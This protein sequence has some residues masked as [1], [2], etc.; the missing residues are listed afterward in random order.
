MPPE[1]ALFWEKREQPAV[2]REN[3]TTTTKLA[4]SAYENIE[5]EKLLQ[6]LPVAAEL[7]YQRKPK[8]EEALTDQTT[9]EE[10]QKTTRAK[11]LKI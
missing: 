11:E 9:A 1:V 5:F 2:T 7:E 6:P 3:W 4:I 8:D 10:R